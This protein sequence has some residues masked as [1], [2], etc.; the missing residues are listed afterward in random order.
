MRHS[1]NRALTAVAM[2]TGAL[3]ALRP[4]IL[5]SSIDPAVETIDLITCPIYLIGRLLPPMA[6]FGSISFLI[7]AVVINAAL[8]GVLARYALRKLFEN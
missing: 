5:A 4:L 1:T 2:I 8:Y 6:D 7:T 3:L